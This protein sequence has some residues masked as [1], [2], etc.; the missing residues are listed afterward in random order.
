[1]TTQDVVTR[2]PAC[3]PTT[4]HA[5]WVDGE[6]CEVLSLFGGLSYPVGDDVAACLP[7]RWCRQATRDAHRLAG[8]RLG[9]HERR[10]LLLAPPPNDDERPEWLSKSQVIEPADAGRA[11]DEAHRR[12]IRKLAE[13]GLVEMARNKV[14]KRIS[15]PRAGQFM[16]NQ[17]NPEDGK[18]YRWH[19]R[20][21]L[22]RRHSVWKRA[23]RLS[24]LGAAV[25]TVIGDGLQP[26]RP[27][28][29]AAYLVGI[30]HA[31]RRPAPDLLPEF[32]NQLRGHHHD[33]RIAVVIGMSFGNQSKAKELMPRVELLETVIETITEKR[34]S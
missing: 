23:V 19:Y 30:L 20:D 25:A 13:H 17:Y 32:V 28:R 27:I 15:D 14:E 6:P 8:V 5:C 16:R 29:W 4:F 18:W 22:T 7:C 21:D 10:I 3:T 33:L 31:C 9:K 34:A 1:M 2:S 11:S 26:G 24:P 12:A